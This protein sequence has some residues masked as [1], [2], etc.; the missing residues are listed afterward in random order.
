MDLGWQSNVSRIAYACRKVIL[1]MFVIAFLPRS[2]CLLI[3]WLQSLSAM[4]LEGSQ[5]NPGGQVKMPFNEEKRLAV[6]Y[7]AYC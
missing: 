5:E 7:A 3:S 6:S 4:I 1:S 2:K